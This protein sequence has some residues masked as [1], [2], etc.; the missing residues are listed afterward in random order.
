MRMARFAIS[1]LYLHGVIKKLE[2]VRKT[3]RGQ[4]EK[5]LEFPAT[6]SEVCTYRGWGMKGIWDT[7]PDIGGI[8]SLPETIK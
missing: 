6:N 8:D 7:H 4:P 5:T 1:W 2:E 3:M